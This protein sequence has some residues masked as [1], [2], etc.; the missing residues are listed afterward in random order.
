MGFASKQ[1][2]AS[3]IHPQDE[4]TLFS[5]MPSNKNHWPQTETQKVPSAYER[6]LLQ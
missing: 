1:L 2:A 6:K 4:S 3:G 5:V